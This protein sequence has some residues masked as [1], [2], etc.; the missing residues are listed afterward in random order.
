MGIA[1]TGKD[2]QNHN[3]CGGVGR[4]TKRVNRNPL[5][6][7]MNRRRAGL[8]A[9]I[10]VVVWAVLGGFAGCSQGPKVELP[11]PTTGEFLSLEEQ[12]ALSASQLSEYCR[13]LNDHLASLRSDIELAYALKDSLDQ[14]Y[15]E[16]N[17]QHAE[18]NT[19]TRVLE[20]E[21]KNRKLARESDTA[22]VTQDGD[23]LMKL[24]S[25]FYGSAAEWRKI[26]DV[27]SDLI[28]DPGEVL[29]TGLRLRIP[30]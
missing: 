12:R 16:Q 26:Y 21:L 11:D 18:L 6:G 10:L 8:A 14:R 1:Q 7:R 28:E 27:N 13:M 9:A 25:L 20:R 19:A 5:S 17:A 23:T 4:M 24:A 15:E 2:A 29:P 30:K 3:R 22:Y